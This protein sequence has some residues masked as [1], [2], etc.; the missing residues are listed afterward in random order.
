[1]WLHH[2]PS[3][4]LFA[5]FAGTLQCPNSSLNRMSWLHHSSKFVFE[6][7]LAVFTFFRIL[8]VVDTSLS[9]LSTLLF[10]FLSEKVSVWTGG[11]RYSSLSLSELL[12]WIGSSAPECATSVFPSTFNCEM[13]THSSDLNALLSLFTWLKQEEIQCRQYNSKE[14]FTSTVPLPQNSSHTNR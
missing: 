4:G 13:S 12:S 6:W 14:L 1:M 2:F 3:D 9:L 10:L 11:S 7:V 5:H 8:G